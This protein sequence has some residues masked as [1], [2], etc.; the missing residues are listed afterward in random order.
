YISMSFGEGWDQTAVEAA[1]S[2]LKLIV[3]DHTAYHTYLDSS[4]ACFIS[5]REV[6]AQVSTDADT[7]ALFAGANWWQPNEEEAA[8]SI[9]AAIDGRE[10]PKTS[11][12]SRVLEC[13]TWTK[14]T[15]RL[16]AMLTE[17]D[18]PGRRWWPF[19]QRRT[20]APPRNTSVC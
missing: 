9:R 3:P 16:I 20:P 6:P 2:G 18:A 1:A 8:I 11:P 7:A 15:Q 17:L 10:E 14:A 12:R 4:V 19:Y 5:S 13:L